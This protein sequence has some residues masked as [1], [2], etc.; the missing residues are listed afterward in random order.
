[1]QLK[2]E[3]A[4]EVAGELG[5]WGFDVFDQK[6]NITIGMKYLE[7]LYRLFPEEGLA[8]WAYHLGMG[9]MLDAIK[10]KV[11]REDVTFDNVFGVVRDENVNF[12]NLVNSDF[13][14]EKIA[15]GEFRNDT[16]H[17]V[18]RILAARQLITGGS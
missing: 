4:S 16:A 1:M 13:M 2:D 7:K 11:R 15:T 6:I 14:K 10:N 8:L 17:Y 9:N 12:E 5:L 3:T 18:P